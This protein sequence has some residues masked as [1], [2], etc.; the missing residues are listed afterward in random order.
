MNFSM[1]RES[2]SQYMLE[3][4]TKEYEIIA[5]TNLSAKD[6][7]EISEKSEIYLRYGVTDVFYLCNKFNIPVTV[8]S[9]GIG[10]FIEILLSQFIDFHVS[11]KSN[12]LVFNE[13]GDFS[14]FSD[15]LIHSGNKADAVKDLK[16][17]AVIG[18][19]DMPSV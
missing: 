11:L 4:W 7:T 5:S 14:K 13:K 12:F 18:I 6:L 3:W 16:T 17:E 15:P 8:L 1:D 10:N 19:G 2:K 9:A